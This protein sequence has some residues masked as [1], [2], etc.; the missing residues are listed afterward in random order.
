MPKAV[1]L[2]RA[3]S[4]LAGIT[5]LARP[6]FM[7]RAAAEAPLDPATLP[8]ELLRDK[9]SEVG[10]AHGHERQVRLP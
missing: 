2:A 4:G 10:S 9:G 3:G 6:I 7:G 1:G 5:A 8:L